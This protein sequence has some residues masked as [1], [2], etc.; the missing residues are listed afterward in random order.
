MFFFYFSV[1]TKYF[2]SNGLIS[3]KVLR[4][5][6][7]HGQSHLEIEKF[8]FFTVEI[9]RILNSLIETMKHREGL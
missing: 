7:H 6:E 4:L 2:P 3:R 8:I 1:S 9:L 5:K